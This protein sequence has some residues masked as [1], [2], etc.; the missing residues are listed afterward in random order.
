VLPLKKNRNS[1]LKKIRE[2]GSL[3]HLKN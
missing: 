2:T 3:I 1:F